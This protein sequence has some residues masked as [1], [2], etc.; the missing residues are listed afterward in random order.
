MVDDG[1][2][3]LFDPSDTS[4]I[5]ALARGSINYITGALNINARGI[6]GSIPAGN[7]INVQYTPYV[8]SRP[9]SVMFYQDQI[10]LYPIPDQAYT[11]SFE[12]Y[13]YPTALEIIA[14]IHNCLNGGN[15]WPWVHP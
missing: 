9:Q 14:I 13:K 5:P 10:Y 3:N 2:G 15:V 1:Q 7:P 4:T 6:H 12:A 11:V 8:A